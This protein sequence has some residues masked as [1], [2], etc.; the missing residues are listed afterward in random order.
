MGK[1]SLLTSDNTDSLSD[2][3]RLSKF[4]LEKAVERGVKLHQPYTAASIQQS[5]NGHIE[6]LKIVPSIPSSEEGIDIPCKHIIITAGAWS[7]RVY[8]TLFPDDKISLPIS[9]LAG[10]SLL[11]RTP[12]WKVGD[13]LAIHLENGSE[14]HKSAAGGGCHAIFTSSYMEGVGEW[15]P[16]IFSRAGGEIY[17]AGLNDAKLPLPRLATERVLEPK[18]LA[19]VMDEAKRLIGIDQGQELEV[20]REGLCFRPITNRGTPIIDQVKPGVWVAAGHGPWGISMSLGTGKVTAESIQGK[21][22][23]A[24]VTRLAL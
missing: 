11:L 7:S 12:Y 16:E 13:E 6:S 24:D 19:I 15:S 5:S 1:C 20:L 17:I 21:E 18:K 2:P 23:S 8:K 3:L 10:H 22:V 9:S 4:L 14:T